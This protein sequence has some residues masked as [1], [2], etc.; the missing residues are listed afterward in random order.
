MRRK[1]IPPV[2]KALNMAKQK[3]TDKWIQKAQLQE[4]AFTGQARRAGM[5]VQEY[6][7]KVLKP[8]SKASAK[9]KKRAVLARTFKKMSGK[10][11]K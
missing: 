6:A 7:G 8:G 4:G 1:A 3:E 5:G 11:N 9:T 10:K 2:L